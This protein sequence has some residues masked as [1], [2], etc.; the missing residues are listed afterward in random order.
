MATKF[1]EVHKK[2]PLS[3]RKGKPRLRSLTLKQLTDIKDREK[4]GKRFE[5]AQKEIVRKHKLG[6]IYNT[7]VA[8]ADDE[9][10]RNN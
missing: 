8:E 4:S 1:R 2:N 5:A 7:S 6:V 3:F 9:E 10:I